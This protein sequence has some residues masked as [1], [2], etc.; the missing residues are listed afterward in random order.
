MVLPPTGDGG[1]CCS[2]TMKEED[3]PGGVDDDEKAPLPF[4]H[5]VVEKSD[6]ETR[7]IG[8]DPFFVAR[9]DR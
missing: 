4:L 9:W 2:D 6:D 1:C 3:R 7:G 8:C 5:I